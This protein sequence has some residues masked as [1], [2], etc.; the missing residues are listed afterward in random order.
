MALESEGFVVF[1]R[2][3]QPVKRHGR[4]HAHA[5]KWPN[6]SPPLKY[7]S[8]SPAPPKV[9]EVEV[10]TCACVDIAS[11]NCCRY[12]SQ[13]C[14]WYDHHMLDCRTA[15]AFCDKDAEATKKIEKLFEGKLDDC[16]KR[17]APNLFILLLSRL[18][19]VGPVQCA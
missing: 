9:V 16:S 1:L 14:D 15:A 5:T 3:Y 10:E 7:R 17:R 6:Y 18:L 8:Y 12:L 11:A 4:K 13:I 19:C 2:S